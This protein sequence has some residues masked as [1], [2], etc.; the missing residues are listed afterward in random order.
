MHS[1]WNQ[2]AL[3]QFLNWVSWVVRC[4]LLKGGAPTVAASSGRTRTHPWHPAAVC[5]RV[6]QLMGHK[7]SGSDD[8]TCVKSLRTL[9]VITSVSLF[10]WDMIECEFSAQ[11]QI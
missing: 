11:Q 1:G 5:S 7:L 8:K 9:F 4:N 6:F 3:S 2:R 10:L